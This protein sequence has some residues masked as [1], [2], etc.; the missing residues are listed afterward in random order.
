[1]DLLKKI[2]DLS[3]VYD[4]NPDGRIG[5]EPGGS[6]LKKAGFDPDRLLSEMTDDEKYNFTKYLNEQAKQKRAQELS[7]KYNLPKQKL[8]GVLKDYTTY[9][10]ESLDALTKSMFKGKK[11]FELGTKD[12]TAVKRKFRNKLKDLAEGKTNFSGG[13]EFRRLYNEALNNHPNV[14][15]RD[16]DQIPEGKLTQARTMAAEDALSKLPKQVRN[17]IVSNVDITLRDVDTTKGIPKFKHG[18]DTSTDIGKLDASIYGSG[19][20]GKLN[21]FVDDVTEFYKLPRGTGGGE[22]SYAR[23]AG[24]SIKDLQK[25]YF[26]DLGTKRVEQLVTNVK[27]KYNIP[28]HPSIKEYEKIH[29]T[30][31]KKAKT[32]TQ[33][34]R[35]KLDPE[36]VKVKRINPLKRGSGFDIAHSLKAGTLDPD[37]PGPQMKYESPDTLY[38]LKQELNRERIALS[39]HTAAENALTKI[40]NDRMKLMEQVEGDNFRVI[41]GKEREFAE[42]QAKGKKIA[43]EF[44][45]TDELFGTKFKGLPG[46][47]KQV[48]GTVNFQIF[49]PDEKGIYK[50]E[51]TTLVGGDTEKSLAKGL[52]KEL[53]KK[54]IKK[55]TKPELKKF[56]VNT[57]RIFKD[58]GILNNIPKSEAG[59]IEKE[60]LRDIA[61]VGGKGVRAATKWFGIPDAIIGTADYL[62]EKSKGKSTEEAR[63]HAIRSLTF[64]AVKDKEYMKGLKKTAESMNIDARAFNDIYNLNVAGQEFDKYYVKGK[65]R[66]KNLRKL[67]YDKAAN[68]LQK[69]LDRYIEEQNQNLTNLN[70]KVLDQVSISKAKGAASPL[71]LSKARDVI[72]MEDYLKPFKDMPKAATEK[73]KREKQ[74]VLSKPGLFGII[75]PKERKGDP[76]EGDITTGFYNLIDSLTQGAKNALQLRIIPGGPERFRPLKSERQKLA[77]ELKNLSPRDLQRFNLGRGLTY[78]TP[79]SPGDIRNLRDYHPGVFYSGGGIAGIRR[80]NAI[81]P[82]RQGLRSIMIG[83]MND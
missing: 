37:K 58:F 26:P 5:F 34:I 41:P 16:L 82:E 53:R 36:G 42:L 30:G 31:G 48:R 62:N 20:E 71:Q 2:I 83:D 14:R 17:S 70:Q 12:R 33:L 55:L 57:V 52:P 73:L 25:K 67:G 45:Y 80:P 10:E 9:G 29:G 15:G 39:K 54:D 21:Q 27:N 50:P 76:A 65:E 81:P 69:N 43:R 38:P 35:D 77:Q 64:G 78:G 46:K 59:Y 32:R 28:D 44:S 51:N 79:I 4:D 66:I 22:F 23:E 7:E 49:N 75:P 74:S 60:L 72:T 19:P 3:D 18:I 13:P 61:K 24:L 1:M 63:A 8:E 68:D 40:H 56:T 11:Y 6:A 47:Q